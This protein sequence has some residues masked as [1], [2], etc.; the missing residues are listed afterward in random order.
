M[1][2]LP[3]DIFL[4]ILEFCSISSHVALALTCKN[5]A[6]WSR[7]L[8]LEKIICAQ[9]IYKNE[10]KNKRDA[11]IADLD[12]Q[13]KLYQRKILKL[14]TERSALDQKS[15]KVVE[16]NKISSKFCL[17]Y[18]ALK[19]N[20]YDE[21]SNDILLCVREKKVIVKQTQ[22]FNLIETLLKKWGYT[23]YFPDEYTRKSGGFAFFSTLWHRSWEP[24]VE[25]KEWCTNCKEI[26]HDY[27]IC[28][29]SLCTLCKK[30]GHASVVCSLTEGKEFCRYCKELGHLIDVCPKLNPYPNNRWSDWIGGPDYP[31]YSMMEFL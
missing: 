16:R 7:D 21:W 15:I 26:G 9:I 12:T 6:K 4:E 8:P 18:L 17:K 27:K 31:Y 5:F 20:T 24:Y 22:E 23:R 30:H 19:N 14:K 11:K 28:P 1:N 10:I 3:R 13:I 25:G 29:D 2:T